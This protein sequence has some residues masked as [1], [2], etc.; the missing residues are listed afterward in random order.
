MMVRKQEIMIQGKPTADI[1][2]A[3]FLQMLRTDPHLC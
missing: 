3:E 2:K 1:F